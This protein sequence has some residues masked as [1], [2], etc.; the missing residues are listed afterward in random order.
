MNE[1]LA[2]IGALKLRSLVESKQVSPVEVAE[3]Y[4]A[5]ID[6]LDP[7]LQFVPHGDGGTRP[8]ER[9]GQPRTP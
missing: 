7:Q 5:R 2:F 4:L 6:R 1:D 9:R 3:M 8:C